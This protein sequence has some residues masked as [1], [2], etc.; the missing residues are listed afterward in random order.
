MLELRSIH[1]IFIFFIGLFFYGSAYS[2]ESKNPNLQFNS[3]VELPLIA[4]TGIAVGAFSLFEDRFTPS[5]CRWCDRDSNGSNDLNGFDSSA[6]S[7]LRWSETGLANNLSHITGYIMAPAFALGSHAWLNLRDDDKQSFYEDSLIISEAT[8]IAGLV[9]HIVQFS[10][11]RERP[12]THFTGTRLNESDRNTSF[13]SGHSTIA[14]ALAASSG[15]VASLRNRTE[16][17]YIWA[18][19][20]M[21]AG[22]TSYLRVAADR[23]Y[24]SDVLMGAA[25]GSVI[26]FAVPYIFHSPIDKRESNQTRLRVAVLP[27][28][29]GLIT[30][31]QLQW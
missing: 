18:T 2:I 3:S 4:A 15:T 28:H 25:A 31:L 20:L 6:R 13:Y 30:S 27:N 9:G 22:L 5:R 7:Q 12:D 23:H 11:G 24:L 17:P 1:G 19:G 10:V 26:G 8:L 14:F 21:L 16:A 29:Q